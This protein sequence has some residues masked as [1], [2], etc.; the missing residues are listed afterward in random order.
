MPTVVDVNTPTFDAEETLLKE[1]N[2]LPVWMKHRVYP[3]IGK[4]DPML[5]VMIN[6]KI[7]I[8]LLDTGAHVSVLPKSLIPEHIEID[9]QSHSG[10][11]VRAFGGQ[12]IEL[13]GP[14]CLPIHICGLNIV[15]PFYYMDTENPII[16]GYDLLCAAMIVISPHAQE[17]WS[18]HPAASECIP[19]QQPIEQDCQSSHPKAQPVSV[20][21]H[22][23]AVSS[24]AGSEARVISQSI[25]DSAHT[26]DVS[27][28]AGTEACV[29]DSSPEVPVFQPQTSVVSS[30]TGSDVCVQ[31]SSVS[32]SAGTEACK[33]ALNPEAPNFNPALLEID[34]AADSN[35]ELPAHINILYE[36]TI[37]NTR[38]TSD[39]DEQF[40]EML[41]KHKD[42]FATDATDIGYC[43]ILAHDIDTGNSPPIKQ[44]PRRPP[45]SAGDA[46]NEIIDEMLTAGV[47]ETST[48]E[49]ASPV[50]LVKKPDGSYRFCIDYRRVN[51]VSRKDAF[52]VP[53]IQDA[54][55]SLRGARWFATIDLLS[56]YWQLGLTDRAK[57]RSAFCTRRGLFQF[58]RM[59]FGLCGAPATFC[60]LMSIVLGDYI[61]AICLCYLDDVIV[62]A[63]TQQELLER[64]DLVFTR[65]RQNGLKIKPSKCVLFRTEIKFLGHLV[66]ASGVQPLP[67][68]VAAIKDWPTPRCLRDVRAFYGLVGYYRR[69]I[70]G[71]ATIAEPLT[72][73]TRKGTK[74]IWTDEADA[75]FKKLKD[76]MLEVPTLAFPY[77]DRPC[78]LDTDSSDVAY[79]SVL[80]QIV[81]GQERPIAFFSRVMSLSQQN[82]CAT[83]RELLAVIGSLQHF[84]HYLL[85]VPVILR[86]DHHS[87]KWLKT[88][89]R[90][91]GI[92]ARWME[93]L[94]EFDITIEHRP[95]RIH[96]NAD[97]LSRQSCKQC[98]GK[99]P[100][101]PWIDELE[102]ANECT[103][104]LGL[105]ALQLLPEL[106]D[107]TVT[108]LQNDDASLGPIRAWLETSYEP[109]V[110][111]LR[112]IP[113]EGRKI[114]TQRTTLT[115]VNDVLVRTMDNEN[116]LV[117][118]DALR[119]RLFDSAHSG[120][121]AA[122]L[123]PDR[124]MAQLRPYYYWPGMAKDVT[125]WCRA[126]DICARSRGAP[127]RAHASMQKV[128][129]A[130]PMDMV[131][132]DILSGL[133]TA[134]D[135][136]TCIL[137]VVDYFTKWA[138]AYALPNE[139]AATC[140]TA[141]Y[142]NFF[143]RFG[144]PTQLH[145]DQGRNFESN[146]VSELTKLTGIRRTRTTPFHP[147]SDGQTERMN[148]TILAMLKATAQENPEDWPDKLP[149]IMS[150]YRMTPHSTTGLSPNKAMMSRETR[151]PPTLIAT[152]PEEIIQPQI[153]YNVKLRDNMRDAHARVREATK[154]SAKT[155]KSYFDARVK[156]IAFQ[157]KQL[158][159]LYWPRPL[160]KMQKRKL[161]QLWVG[162]YRILSFKSD[163][164]VEIQHIKTNK[165]QV[166]HVDRLIPCHT[167]VDIINPPKS[168]TS[169]SSPT[170]STSP[171]TSTTNAPIS[172]EHQTSRSAEQVT[173]RPTRQSQRTTRKPV[174]Y[175]D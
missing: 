27:S 89:K 71:F 49:W 65:L 63:K 158:V 30:A 46:E 76:C 91:E 70:A 34:N 58:K 96:S 97:G 111:D 128:I 93:T 79:G 144:L 31:P 104:S 29:H 16:G 26:S 22:T 83:R 151:A 45:L 90:P 173:T 142:Q 44:S 55:D 145:S 121:L 81:D 57:E 8:M 77:P 126:C 170:P 166:V 153:P 169:S 98:W 141:V 165:K 110:D 74:F 168:A 12:E 129:A 2:I 68:K 109:T 61:G 123:G 48:S 171:E 115:F 32:S 67:D 23:S 102:R 138:E 3:L 120:P 7:V 88:F 80:S 42:T 146:L 122:H 125:D 41:H 174:R 10:R 62:F 6:N 59:P 157:D 53:D 113:P 50:C 105:H 143:S 69:F 135:G 36:A 11:W 73:L 130:A 87:L 64:L 112:Q 86:T 38:L 28:G 100:K 172:S 66:T 152:P 150:A 134:S 156:A 40:R 119:K 167:V 137:V 52:P 13:A 154:A 175:R 14:I 103:Y 9:S 1:T 84:R 75:A 114:W 56:G 124:T 149:M 116:Q 131:A 164:V 4:K 118:P 117:V 43:P 94:S 132:I 51:A 47:I 162:P 39:V 85:N 136:S 160:V 33:T 54:L 25:G 82:Y 106:S 15:H 20:I 148:R 133:P 155:Q 147:R 163:V 139:E 107:E 78:I 127:P 18:M 60:R 99:L 72:R 101:T 21:T 37:A 5:Q 35:D 140:M 95:G 161:A 24:S 17:V 92:L 19:S 159:W 108:E